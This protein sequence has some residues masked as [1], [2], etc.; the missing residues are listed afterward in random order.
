VFPCPSLHLLPCYPISYLI[1][2]FLVPSQ[3]N[4]CHWGKS[5]VIVTDP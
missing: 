3:E 4:I 1:I 2:P 5:S